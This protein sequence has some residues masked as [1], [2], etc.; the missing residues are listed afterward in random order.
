MST[1]L[2]ELSDLAVISKDQD[3]GYRNQD[4]L[5]CKEYELSH[6]T[7]T[8]P[9]KGLRLSPPW[10]RTVGSNSTVITPTY[11]TE[12]DGEA[13]FFPLPPATSSI[14]LNMDLSN[15]LTSRSFW[16][17]GRTWLV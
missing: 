13:D 14:N 2:I 15:I 5:A 6:R 9:A 8:K 1:R 3:T 17:F 10:T 7:K 11:G 12:K 4:E 16:R